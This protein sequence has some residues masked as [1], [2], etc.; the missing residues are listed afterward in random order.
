MGVGILAQDEYF[1]LPSFDSV[2][3]QTPTS[4]SKENSPG[5]HFD[6]PL[7]ESGEVPHTEKHAYFD[8]KVQSPTRASHKEYSM[9][10]KVALLQLN[11]DELGQYGVCEGAGWRWVGP[12]G[13]WGDVVKT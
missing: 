5:E 12:R 4:T 3:R 8:R 13:G 1:L 9:D 2:R 10:F 11:F 6:V 7:H